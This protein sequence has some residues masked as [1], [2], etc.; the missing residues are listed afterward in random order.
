MYNFKI[1][2]T[3]KKITTLFFAILCCITILKAEEVELT[4]HVET[5]GTL[6]DKI[7]DAGQRPI[8]VTKLTVTGTLNDDDFT[9]M[10]ETMTSLVDIDLSGI[11]NTTGV[12]F[13]GKN[14]LVKI[15]L[16]ENLT[17]IGDWAFDCCLSLTSITIPNSVTSIESYA[18]FY[19]SSLTSITIP[20]SV[21]SI[22]C[23]AFM[24]CSSLI[25]ITIPNSVTSIGNDAFIDCSSLTS[26][27]IPNSV[28]S[29]GD[30]AFSSC[31]SLTSITIPN[32]V[33]SIGDHAFYNCSSLT[34]ITIEATTP[35]T[36]N[37]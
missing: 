29:I 30:N 8:F 23:G 33:T 15:L 32:S 25:S 35:P 18:F 7:F 9:C 12:N 22:G 20:N 34:S 17:S 2:T 3:M 36:L 11:T 21:T 31:S 13:K 19:C 10:R 14:N 1:F 27:T 4:I 28:T 37:D 24:Y 6:S 26:I 5:P 16:P